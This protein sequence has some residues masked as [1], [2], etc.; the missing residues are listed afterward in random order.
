MRFY[1]PFVDEFGEHGLRFTTEALTDG[2]F[3]W[4]DGVVIMTHHTDVDYADLVKRAKVVIDTRNATKTV[5]EGREK[6]VLL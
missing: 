2:L 6:I 3:E 4:A 1:D 5:T